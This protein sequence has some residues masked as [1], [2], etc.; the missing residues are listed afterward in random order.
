MC[1]VSGVEPHMNDTDTGAIMNSNVVQFPT[2]AKDKPIEKPAEPLPAIFG[3][4]R[5]SGFST[6]RK[7]NTS[8]SQKVQREG[9][10]AVRNN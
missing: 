1:K 3:G 4:V 2:E 8:R 10:R 7:V 9:K 6:A 5:R